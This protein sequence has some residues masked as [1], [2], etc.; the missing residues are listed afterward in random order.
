LVITATIPAGVSK[1]EF[2]TKTISASNLISG[3]GTNIIYST[4]ESVNLLDGFTASNG[5]DFTA[6][7]TS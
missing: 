5:T 7:I 2:A 4:I 1:E 6:R 3:D